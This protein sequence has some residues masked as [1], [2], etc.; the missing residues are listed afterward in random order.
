MGQYNGIK[1]TAALCNAIVDTLN[2]EGLMD[3]TE[4]LDAGFAV[5]VEGKR[6]GTVFTEVLDRHDLEEYDED[7]LT[8]MMAYGYRVCDT[9][10][11]IRAYARDYI[12]SMYGVIR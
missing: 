12:V 1:T 2:A 10:E 4:I 7:Q 3:G 6:N 9:L 11:D 5:Y 8:D